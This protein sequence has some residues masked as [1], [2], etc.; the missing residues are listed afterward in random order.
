MFEDVLDLLLVQL[1]VERW[2]CILTVFFHFFL[3][4]LHPLTR[5]EY[6]RCVFSLTLHC[7]APHF[8]P[9]RDVRPI[10]L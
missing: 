3:T 2:Q 9:T 1:A 5:L 10:C 8:L 7:L 6:H 4:S